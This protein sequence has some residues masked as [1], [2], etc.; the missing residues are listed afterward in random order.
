[1]CKEIQPVHH[2]ED[3]FWVFF[4]RTD[5]E[6]ETP[7]LWPPDVKSWLIEKTLM[8]GKIEGRRRG[9][10][11]MRRLDGITDSMDMLLLLLLLLSCFSRVRLC[12]TPQMAAHQAP[13]SLGFSSQEYWS[14]LPF[15]SP[16]HAC[17]LSHF[18]HVWS[19]ATPWTTSSQGPPSMGFSRREYW[20]GLPL[21][22]PSGHEFG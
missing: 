14:G 13:L 8:L 4:G 12:A 20:S 6:A 18:S 7:I 2:K 1:M 10:Q 17:V 19:C 21:P 15:P 9:W 5:V 22:S 3:Q 16:M 11:R